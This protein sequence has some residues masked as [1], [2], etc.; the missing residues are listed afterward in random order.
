MEQTQTTPSHE[1]ADGET[2][3]YLGQE[4]KLCIEADRIER[5]RLIDGT[6]FVGLHDPAD[7]KRAGVLIERWYRR[8]AKSVFSE[9]FAEACRHMQPLGIGQPPLKIRLMRSRW[10]SCSSKGNITLNPKL[11]QVPEP[12]L[13]Y[14]IL[15]ELC[16]LIEFNH[17]PRFWALMDQ[18]MPGWKAHRKALKTVDVWEMQ[19]GA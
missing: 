18:V 17:S 10:G 19:L 1:F 5:V 6:L 11:I 16:H 3:H 9:L 15:H 13:R 7:R 12:L 8:R 14:V 2:F 4:V